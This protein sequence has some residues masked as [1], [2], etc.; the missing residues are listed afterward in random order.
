MES[1]SFLTSHARA[2]LCIAHDLGMRLRDIAASM[3]ITDRGAYG[4]G[5]LLRDR[6]DTQAPPPVKLGQPPLPTP[7][8]SR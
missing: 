8:C 2:L 5:G 6:T 7:G 3:G 1:W 4:A